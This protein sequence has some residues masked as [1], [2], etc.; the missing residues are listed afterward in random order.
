MKELRQVSEEYSE[1]GFDESAELRSA[2]K[3]KRKEK[4]QKKKREF[5]DQEVYY[6]SEFDIT[7]LARVDD[8]TV[9]YMTDDNYSKQWFYPRYTKGRLHEPVATQLLM[10]HLTQDSVFIDVGAHLGYFS[11]LAASKA[12]SVYAIEVLEFL[13]PRIHRNCVAN[14]YNNVFTIFAAA[15]DK[16]GFVSVPKVGG[17]NNKVG[18][19]E[20]KSLVPV[21]R[22]DDYFADVT[23]PMILK[24]DTEGFEYQVLQGAARILERK[25]KMLIE[26]HRNMK[27]YG[28]T[29][30]DMYRLLKTYGYEIY[31]LE[32]RKS[33]GAQKECSLE[34]IVELNNAMILCL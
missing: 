32:H 6:P 4:R 10:D 30:A 34:E 8:R 28:F 2:N 20:H 33:S 15:G 19:S 3:Q 31:S 11:M 17:P 16:P 25:P 12:K 18:S 7:Y 1:M 5:L 21:I 9:I 26:V 14:H 24:I 27:N 13:I 29:V 22:L 23:E